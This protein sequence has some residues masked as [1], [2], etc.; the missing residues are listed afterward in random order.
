MKYT[1]TYTGT[2]QER[3][4]QGLEDAKWYCDRA[5]AKTLKVLR[6]DAQA[7]RAEGASRTRIL[8]RMRF[9]LSVTG[10]GSYWAQRAMIREALKG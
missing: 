8:R 1:R 7:I 5:F 4:K 10:I 9:L 6:E 3:E 2:R